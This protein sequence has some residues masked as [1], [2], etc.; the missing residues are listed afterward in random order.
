MKILVEHEVPCEKGMEQKCLY[1][2]TTGGMMSAGIIRTGTAP[3]DGKP[4]W[5][6]T[7]QNVPCSMSGCLEST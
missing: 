6:A 3:T 2:G 5:S 4:R 1:L 7:F